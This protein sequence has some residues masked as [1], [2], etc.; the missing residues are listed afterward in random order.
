MLDRADL[1]ANLRWL[2]KLRTTLASRAEEI[3]GE[4][5]CFRRCPLAEALASEVL[6]LLESVRFLERNLLADLR[7]RRL[8]RAGRPWWL[9]GVVALE[10]WRPRGRV[11]IVAPGNYPLFLAGSQALQALAAGNTVVWK[12][13]P[14]AEAPARHFAQALGAAGGPVERFSIAQSTVEAV[15]REIETGLDLAVFTGSSTHGRKLLAALAE[16]LVPAVVELSGCDSVWLRPDADLRLAARSVA[17]GLLLNRGRTC[18]APRRLLVPE[19]LLAD[20][21]EELRQ[22]LDVQ[23]AASSPDGSLHSWPDQTLAAV[24]SALAAGARESVPHKGS[25]D[26][27][28]PPPVMI[29][30]GVTPTMPVWTQDL[31]APVACLVTYPDEAT[32]LTWE[33][34]C[35]YRLGATVFGRDHGAARKLACA[36]PAPTVSINELIVATADPRL[37]FEGCGE[38]GYGATRGH[39]GLRAMAQRQTILTQTWPFHPHLD[40]KRASDASLLLKLIRWLHR[41]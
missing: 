17:Y 20:F 15:Y 14:G 8:P 5:A 34:A 19:A 35:P 9:G 29:L 7:P 2:R 4:L 41:R 31:F 26:R 11:L 28:A 21:R 36:L 22:A 38:S 37:T 6:P 12:P 24:E 39:G 40:P 30:E 13:A 32:A 1:R 3:A 18:I 27:E 10:G 16:R 33:Q 25:F 23:L